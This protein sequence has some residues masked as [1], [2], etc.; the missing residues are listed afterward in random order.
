METRYVFYTVSSTKIFLEWASIS[1][2]FVLASSKGSLIGKVGRLTLRNAAYGMKLKISPKGAITQINLKKWYYLFSKD[3]F[4]QS[5]LSRLD[6]YSIF[7]QAPITSLTM[8]V[9][10]SEENLVHS[11]SST[12]TWPRV[13]AS[14]RKVGPVRGE[15]G[16]VAVPRPSGRRWETVSPASTFPCQQSEPQI[17]NNLHDCNGAWP[18]TNTLSLD[19]AAASLLLSKFVK[20]LSGGKPEQCRERELWET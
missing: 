5:R 12:E 2:P 11:W 19:I 9:T 13:G 4:N 8:W 3:F 16:P 14:Q 6:I 10:V 20:K 18:N 15:V 17:P 7:Y 1:V